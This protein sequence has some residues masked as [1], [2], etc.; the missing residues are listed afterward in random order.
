MDRFEKEIWRY[1]SLTSP[2]ARRGNG[3]VEGC[4]RVITTA[5]CASPQARIERG[6]PVGVPDHGGVGSPVHAGEQPVYLPLCRLSPRREHLLL[7]RRQVAPVRIHS[8]PCAAHLGGVVPRFEL[9]KVRIHLQWLVAVGAYA[10][11]RGR[12]SA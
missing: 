8:H 11:S 12:A 2:G 4:N 9:R 7:L 5:S 6:T 10:L 3:P 1:G